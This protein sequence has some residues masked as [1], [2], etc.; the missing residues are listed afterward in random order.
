MTLLSCP[1]TKITT[2]QDKR[3]LWQSLATLGLLLCV[4]PMPA[5][6][7]WLGE[8]K[9]RMGTEVSVYLWHEDAAVAGAAVDA[10]FAEMDRINAVMS[11][12]VEDSRISYINREA[13]HGWVDAG[14]E[15]FGLVARS[16]EISAMTDG[17]FD[18]TYDS[19]GQFYD[20]RARQ[21]PG[22]AEIDAAL[23]AID[24][25]L[26]ETDDARHALHFRREGV[27]IN[28]GGIAKGYAVERGVQILRE[29]G[30]R[31]ARVTAGGDTRLLGSR[32]GQPWIIG[33]RDPDREGEVSIRLPLEDEA[34]STSGD[35]ERFFIEGGTR[36]HHILSPATGVPAEGVRSATVVGPDAVTTDALSTSV[37]VMGVDA[38]LRLI[39]RLP[40]YEAIVIDAD[41]QLFYSDG[42]AAP[43]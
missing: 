34:I 23:D 39:A 26:V 19:V 15:L 37:F 31:S 30:I 36:Y 1:R 35:Y 43:D 14:E 41:G 11:T 12:Y 17:A 7:E 25:R 29:H 20:F 10:V 42:F 24:Y 6:A 13:A 27:R 18:I 40:G 2:Q 22:A 4:L 9:P 33:V 21:R 32:R 8:A 3:C 5:P 16:L 28:L 38:G